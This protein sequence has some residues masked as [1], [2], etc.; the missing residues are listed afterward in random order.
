MRGAVEYSSV[1]ACADKEA[2][3]E[4]G[5]GVAVLYEVDHHGQCG[6][7]L[8][9]HSKSGSPAWQIDRMNNLWLYYLMRTI[10]PPGV[11]T[12]LQFLKD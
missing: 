7:P 1:W 12:I 9:D 4:K 5:N 11:N 6:G 10:W 3:L 8:G 2:S